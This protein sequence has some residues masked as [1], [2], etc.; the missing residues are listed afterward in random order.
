MKKRTLFLLILV[1]IACFSSL[2]FARPKIL[3]RE[4]DREFSAGSPLR[5]SQVSECQTENLY[6]LCKVWGFVKY[7]HPSVNDGT[8]NW[9]AELL[10]VLPELL[11]CDDEKEAD[12]VLYSWLSGFPVPELE[13]DEETESWLELQK[14]AGWMEA[15]TDWITDAGFLGPE[16]R[17]Y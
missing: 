13:I 10:R 14:E 3:P 4:Q 11:E 1:L 6:K 9:D 12:Q 15:D 8:L 5:L 7:Y 16:V 2:Y 17:G